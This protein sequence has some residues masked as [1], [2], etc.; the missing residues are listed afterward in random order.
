TL[1]AREAD[2][3]TCR[4]GLDND[5]EMTLQ[6]IAEHLSLTRERVRQIQ[7][8]ALLKLKNNFSHELIDFL[9]PG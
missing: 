2:I 6:D 7:N 1:P 3:I 8:S 5:H 4:F 9:E